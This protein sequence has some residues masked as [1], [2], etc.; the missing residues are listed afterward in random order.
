MKINFYPCLL[1]HVFGMQPSIRH[2]GFSYLDQFEQSTPFY[3]LF[4][5]KLNQN[6]SF[7]QT[8]S[9]PVWGNATATVDDLSTCLG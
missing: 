1:Q 5:P 2:C 8:S 6:T 9:D 4:N 7:C 3:N